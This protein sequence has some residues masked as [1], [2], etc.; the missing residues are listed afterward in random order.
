MSTPRSEQRKSARFKQ[1]CIEQEWQKLAESAKVADAKPKPAIPKLELRN[2]NDLGSPTKTQDKSAWQSSQSDRSADSA[3]TQ[4]QTQTQSQTI[5]TTQTTTTTTQTYPMAHTKPV[6]TPRKQTR[7]A[8]ETISDGGSGQEKTSA[9]AEKTVDSPRRTKILSRET[10]QSRC[11][12]SPSVS[13]TTTPSSSPAATPREK[14]QFES[15]RGLKANQFRKRISTTFSKVALDLSK[16]NDRL[17]S[18]RNSPPSSPSSAGRV[19]PS[20]IT[21]R[22][23]ESAFVKSLPYEVR[24]SAAKCFIKLQKVCNFQH[25]FSPRERLLIYAGMIGVLS[26]VGKEYDLK[27]LEALAIDAENRSKNMIIDMEVDLSDPAYKSFIANAVDGAF[28]KTWVKDSSDVVD[29]NGNAMGDITKVR[30]TF[31]R[32]FKNSTYK[33][34]E[35]D[36]SLT[37]ISSIDTFLDFFDK[38]EN[39][40]IGKIVSNIASQNLGMFFKNV[41]FRRE[42]ENGECQSI[43]RLTDGTPIQP[44]SNFKA[45]YILSRDSKGNVIIDYELHCDSSTGK[46][47]LRANTIVDNPQTIEIAENANLTIKSTVVIEPD[48]EW[49][50]DNPHVYAEFWNLKKGD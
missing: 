19:S 25:P 12:G 20:K 41:L 17:A 22:K 35:K 7:F 36:G 31:I 23:K 47:K 28:L 27:K 2:I 4:T 15:P 44:L 3:R 11:S 30:P 34:K 1:E 37:D 42:D 33:I 26:D 39:K 8:P 5:T 14:D 18:G 40:N 16:L 21:P 24:N 49:S 46:S 10:A 50:I 13:T 43:L 45:T 29:S 32:D 9:R 48:G 6:I 38:H